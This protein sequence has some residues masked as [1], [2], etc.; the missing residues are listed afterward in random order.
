MWSAQEEHELKI[1]LTNAIYLQS[2]EPEV[3]I[4]QWVGIKTH[5]R[6]HTHFKIEKTTITMKF[7]LNKYKAQKS[8]LH[9]HE[10][11]GIIKCV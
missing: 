7:L 11:N 10:T 6:M 2:V 1:D 3:I 5:T 9:G 4:V 8:H